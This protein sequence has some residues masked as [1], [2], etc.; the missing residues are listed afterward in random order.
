MK[1][2]F[3]YFDDSSSESDEEKVENF[4]NG[5]YSEYLE[6]QKKVITSAKTELVTAANRSKI[7]VE[8]I[9][10]NL[11]EGNVFLLHDLGNRIF[12]SNQVRRYIL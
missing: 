9:T 1:K 8:Q 5:K 4:I 12:F 11:T 7:D 3:D 10:T 2:Y 6:G